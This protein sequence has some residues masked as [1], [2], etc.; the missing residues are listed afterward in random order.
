MKKALS[1][2]LALAMVFALAA[3]GKK[4][5]APSTPD[6]FG[7]G[8]YPKL[9]LSISTSGGDTGIDTLAAYHFADLF[10]E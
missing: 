8:S 2:I 6:A 4:D 1:L 9:Q 7:D 5:E 3:C 10:S